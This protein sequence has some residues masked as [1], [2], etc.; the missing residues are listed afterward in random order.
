MEDLSLYAGV[1]GLFILRLGVPMLVLV[2]LGILLDR[3][4]SHR[5]HH[6][7]DALKPKGSM[8]MPDNAK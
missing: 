3:W 8:D 6:I 1:I 7:Q 4:Q 5:N 2:S